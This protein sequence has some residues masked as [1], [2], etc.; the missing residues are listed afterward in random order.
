MPYTATAGEHRPGRAYVERFKPK[1]GQDA[2]GYN[3]SGIVAK[4]QTI[5]PEFKGRRAEQTSPQAG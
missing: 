3:L 5:A 4:L 2:N 1:K